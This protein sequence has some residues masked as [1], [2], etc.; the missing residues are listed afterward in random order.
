MRTD[1]QSETATIRAALLEHAD[2]IARIF[3]ESAEHHSGLDPELYFVPSFESIVE[4]YREGRQH[5][6]DSVGA[7][8]TFI[9][10]IKGEIVGFV[11]ARLDRS[12]DAMHRNMVFCHIAEI[13]VSRRYQSRGIGAQLLREAEAWGRD[14]GASVA[15]LE[16]HR[17]NA[18]AGAFYQFRMG[19][20]VTSITAL[21]NL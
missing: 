4:R 8:I 7:N 16:Y 10:E 15:L 21:K 11:D 2:R 20:R 9:A 13:A 12:L 19:Y 14:Q 18:Q 5:P 6:R 17:A 1:F 3:L